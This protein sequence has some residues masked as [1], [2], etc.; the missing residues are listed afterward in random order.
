LINLLENKTNSGFNKTEIRFLALGNRTDFK[1]AE[2]NSVLSFVK[3][4]VEANVAGHPDIENSSA[5]IHVQP[6]HASNDQASIEACGVL[7]YSRAFQMDVVVTNR[8]IVAQTNTS[9]KQEK[10]CRRLVNVTYFSSEEIHVTEWLV[11][12]NNAIDI[13][14]GFI[15]GISKYP[16]L[17]ISSR[18]DITENMLLQTVSIRNSVRV[19]LDARMVMLD[20]MDI[21]PIVTSGGGARGYSGSG[22]VDYLGRLSVIHVGKAPEMELHEDMDEASKA[23]KKHWEEAGFSEFVTAKELCH[24]FLRAGDRGYINAGI[25]LGD[26]SGN[27]TYG[28]HARSELDKECRERRQLFT[29]GSMVRFA[30]HVDSCANLFAGSTAA[31]DDCETGWRAEVE[32]SPGAKSEF[33]KHCLHFVNQTATGGPSSF[34]HVSREQ[35]KIG[36][37][38]ALANLAEMCIT[39]IELASLNPRASGVGGW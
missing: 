30:P 34:A 20:D 4:V 25:K 27:S 16:S 1:F 14:I 22:Y 21:F 35:C 29:A 12:E 8:H 6:A 23:I 37:K 9:Y 15:S 7:A 10:G 32:S 33:I 11:P 2:I 28:A 24:R 39:S 3:Q 26:A 17:N 38:I 18:H 13:S 5:V 31:M 36:W 19:A